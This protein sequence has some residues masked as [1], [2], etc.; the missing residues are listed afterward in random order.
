[1]P[2]NQSD[3]DKRQVGQLSGHFD[4]N[5][6]DELFWSTKSYVNTFDDKRW[7][8][9]SAAAT[10]QNR[11]A[12]EIQYG[13]ITSL[14]YHP[15]IAW[16]NDFS[17]ETG[18][19]VQYQDNKS[20]RYL[21]NNRVATSQTR[22]QEFGFHDYGG[23]VQMMVKPF[24]W[25]KITPGFRVDQVGGS[26]TNHLTGNSYA[27]NN[28]GSI[29]QP[30]IGVVLTPL[31]G[32]S[33]YGNWGKTYQVAVGAATY[34]TSPTATD[35]AP[36]I[37]EGW[38][39]GVKVKPVSW[40][41]GR[42]AYWEQSA[43]NEW[44][45]ILNSPNG[46]STNIG[47]TNRRGVDIQV[48]ISPIEKV[49]LWGTYSLQEAIIKNPAPATPQYA[50]NEVDHTPNYVFSTGI[51]YQPTPELKASLWATGQGNYYLDSANSGS[52]FGEY[53]LLN[54]DLSYKV[55]K[56]VELQFQAKNLTNTYWEYVWT[57]GSQSLHAPGDGIAFYGAVNVNYDFIK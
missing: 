16:L 9:F 51:D 41:E 15:T 55:H 40:A 21:T 30:K 33:L 2:H 43:T 38:E 14:T 25:L 53:A 11:V 39:I 45:R 22:D 3:G 12:E 18:F 26:F 1:M 52:Q 23:Y 8:T 35:L 46:D 10:Q 56:N 28:Y 17:V 44:Q 32:Y 24:D 54:L 36:S 19:D 31:E 13:A 37:N 57:D 7:V 20:A 6:S 48:K 5:L 27:I 50:G 4:V 29:W 42:V 34:K 49:S 47:A